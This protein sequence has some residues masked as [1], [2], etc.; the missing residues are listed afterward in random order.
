MITNKIRTK[1]L[2]Y[3]LRF[4]LFSLGVVVGIALRHYYV[5]P[6][7]ETLNIIDVVSVITTILIAVYIPSVL[8]KNMQVKQEKKDLV[9]QRIDELQNF[10]GKINNLVQQDEITAKEKSEIQN[11]LDIIPYRL[12]TI[13]TLLNYLGVQSSFEVEIQKLKSLNEKYYRLITD[14][15]TQNTTPFYSKT[16]KDEE[17]ELYN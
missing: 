9:N 5:I 1:L 7:D 13:I 17:E 15:N 3:L 8:D 11:T 10:Y 6:L 14:A 4:I 2:N 16:T 12:D